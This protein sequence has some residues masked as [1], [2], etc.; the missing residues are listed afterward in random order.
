MGWPD[1]YVEDVGTRLTA[2]GIDLPA[3]SFAF[4]QLEETLSHGVV[5]AVATPNHAA[6]QVVVAQEPLP[7]VSGE[8]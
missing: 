5:M 8:P 1:A 7:F 4:G 2:R 6:D 3:H